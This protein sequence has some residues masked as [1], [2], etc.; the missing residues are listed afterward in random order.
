[1]KQIAVRFGTPEPIGFREYDGKHPQI[2]LELELR[3]EGTVTVTYY[4]S[5][6][7]GGDDEVSSKARE[8][9]LASISDSIRAWP[10]G[11]SLWKNTTKAVLEEHIDERLAERGITAKTEIISFVLTPESEELYRAAVNDVCRQKMFVD[12]LSCYKN[13]IDGNEGQ[14]VTDKSIFD[15]MPP[16]HVNPLAPSSDDKGAGIDGTTVLGIV[17]NGS[18]P[19][20]SK[21]KYCRHCGAKRENGAKFCPVCGAGFR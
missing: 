1:M 19:N 2:D 16:W 10:E 4:D 12:I 18:P 17:P 15:G 8:I 3:A 7:Y 5:A 9:A 13:V 6:L 11:K 21:D 14:P 20:T